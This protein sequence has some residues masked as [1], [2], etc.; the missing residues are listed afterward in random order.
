MVFK[1]IIGATCTCLTVVSLNTN[2]A[3]VSRLGGQAVYDTEL[4]VTL[5]ADANLAESNTFGI[6]ANGA[7]SWSSGKP[8]VCAVQQG[9]QLGLTIKVDC[10]SL[11]GGKLIRGV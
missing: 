4:N 6:T 1:S 3:L 9:N 8:I 2:A 10:Y 11:T 7:M 5:I